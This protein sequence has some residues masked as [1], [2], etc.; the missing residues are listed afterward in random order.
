[1][2]EAGYNKWTPPVYINSTTTKEK[3]PYF[4]KYQKDILTTKTTL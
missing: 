1:M 4:S 2:P 3:V